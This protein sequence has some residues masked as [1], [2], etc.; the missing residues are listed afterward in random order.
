MTTVYLD[1]RLLPM[2]EARISPLD[3]GFLYGDGVYEVIRVYG[4]KPLRLDAHL[5]R[6][7]YSLRQMRINASAD[8]LRDVPGRVLEAN[9]LAAGQ[10]LVYLQVT[11]GAPAA[12]RHVFPPADV[13]PTVFAYAWAYAPNEA[14]AGPGVDVWL[15]SDVR[16][17]RCDIKS[18]SLI[19]NVMAQQHAVEQGGHEALFV[20]DGVVL[21]GTHSNLFAVFGGEVR[22]APLTNYVLPGVTR[23]IALELCAA[24]GMPAREV[25]ILVHEFGQADEA[26]V[27]STTLEISPVNSVDGRRM[28]SDRPIVRRLQALFRDLV[29][30]ECGP[31]GASARPS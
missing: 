4:G 20:R 28:A 17:S 5:A 8:N 23:Q 31:E 29:A 16:W 7:G 21:E 15:V 13:P 30:R 9:G 1:G 26:F 2:G 27:A 10:A 11:R 3:R 6:L 25:P 12:R 18:I 14:H 19:P 24:A 22:T